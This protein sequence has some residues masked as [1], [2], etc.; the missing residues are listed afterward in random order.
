MFQ[1]GTRL[2][3][4]FPKLNGLGGYLDYAEYHH[5]QR[6]CQRKPDNYTPDTSNAV[7]VRGIYHQNC[8]ADHSSSVSGRSDQSH[9]HIAEIILN[10]PILYKRNVGVVVLVHFIPPGTL[11]NSFSSS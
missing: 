9:F 11:A 2:I 7:F 3:P 5:P 4:V 6:Y 10:V 1:P 8:L